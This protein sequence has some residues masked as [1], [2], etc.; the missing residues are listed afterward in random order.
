MTERDDGGERRRDS[1]VAD[2]ESE[3]DDPESPMDELDEFL[4]ADVRRN[5]PKIDSGDE[6]TEI[7]EPDDG[8]V[9]D[10]SSG[11]PTG[12]DSDAHPDT[13]SLLSSDANG[14]TMV[15]CRQCGAEIALLAD[16]C[17]ACGYDPAGTARDAAAVVLAFGVVLTI[18]VPPAGVLALFVGVVLVGWSFLRT[19]GTR[20]A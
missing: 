16:E 8:S 2:P 7:D 13:E 18:A 11:L 14:R 6:Y 20:A 4:R 17:L 10:G 9:T 19:P 12:T 1:S 15:S 5:F 3:T